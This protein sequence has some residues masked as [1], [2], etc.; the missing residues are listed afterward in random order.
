MKTLIEKSI[1]INGMGH[2]DTKTIFNIESEAEREEL[3][4]KSL[5]TLYNRTVLVN[6]TYTENDVETTNL[7][8]MVI[9]A[10]TDEQVIKEFILSEITKDL[11]S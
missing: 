9:P 10:S 5:A 2:P 7:L 3:R 1:K 4:F 11:N 8:K 6:Y